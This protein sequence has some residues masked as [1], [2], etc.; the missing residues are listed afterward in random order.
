MAANW[1][2]VGEH[3]FLNA[4]RITEVNYLTTKNKYEIT[5]SDKSVELVSMFEHATTFDIS[6]ESEE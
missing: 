1:L 4:N 3:R 2:K 5:Y 6:D